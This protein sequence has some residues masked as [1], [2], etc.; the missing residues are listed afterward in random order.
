MYKHI[1]QIS[2][3]ITTI[4]VTGCTLEMPQKYNPCP[5]NSVAEVGKL[6]YILS[7]DNKRCN[8]DEC[9]NEENCCPGFSAEQ[10]QWAR[11]AFQFNVC[12]DA[13]DFNFCAKDNDGLYYCNNTLIVVQECQTN[14]DCS[15]Q[16]GISIGVCMDGECMAQ[17][18]QENYHLNGANCEVDTDANCGAP[19]NACG[20]GKKCVKGKCELTCPPDQTICGERCVNFNQLHIESCSE[21]GKITCLTSFRNC[22]NN[23]EDG[24]EI[25]LQNELHI[26]FCNE[27]TGAIFCEDNYLDCDMKIENGC[28]IQLHDQ[29]TH[30]A[31]CGEELG[32]ITCEPGFVNCDDSLTNGCETPLH[33]E[34]NIDS[35]DENKNILCMEGYANCDGNNA[36]GCEKPTASQHIAQCEDAEIKTC[37]DGWADCDK[38][39]GNGCET[40]IYDDS[41]N[42]G[43][44]NKTCDEYQACNFGTCGI[45]CSDS[46]FACQNQCIQTT[47]HVASCANDIV[48]CESG[49]G[50][51]DGEI[52]NGCVVDLSNNNMNCGKC[53][54]E[55]SNGHLCEN[56]ECSTNCPQDAILCQDFCYPPAM[57]VKSCSDAGNLECAT[58]YKNCSGDLHDG[59]EINIQSDSN[60]CG[61]CNN[62]CAEGKSCI[63]GSCTV[64][65]LSGQKNCGG[66]CV[67]IAS[68]H[69]QDCTEAG[70]LTCV[71][72]FLDCDKNVSNGCEIDMS[73]MHVASCNSGTLQCSL[74]YGDCD[75]LPGNG[76]ETNTMTDINH[77]SKCNNKCDNGKI[78]SSG[79][80]SYNCGSGTTACQGSCLPIDDMHIE[81]CPETGA[82]IC[83]AEYADCDNQIST[84]CEAKIVNDDKNC[85]A[86]G[87]TCDTQNMM[88]CDYDACIINNVC[89]DLAT[90]SVD[91]ENTCVDLNT[92]VNNCGTCG[93]ACATGQACYDGYCMQKCVLDS[94]CSGGKC[95]DGVCLNCT[96]YSPSSNNLMELCYTTADVSSS[97]QSTL[98]FPRAI[99]IGSLTLNNNKTVT[100]INIPNMRSANIITINAN[101]KLKK[102]TFDKLEDVISHFEITENAALNSIDMHSLIKISSKNFSTLAFNDL[103][104]SLSLTS[105]SSIGK[106]EIS[107]NRSLTTIEFPSL[108]TIYQSLRIW[109]N[110]T[111]TSLS[112]PI[113]SY[114]FALTIKYNAMLDSTCAPSDYTHA[115]SGITFTENNNNE[116]SSCD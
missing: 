46:K 49:W 64:S 114:V 31:G 97:T 53:N 88:F 8:W 35:C 52:S 11:E 29:D 111:L 83:K 104:S 15:N 66:E 109:S 14:N 25:P 20:N 70:A 38:E 16:P 92:N 39:Y 84:G 56:S 34:L 30:I 19:G 44:C 77:C 57:H 24:C 71:S 98:T 110:A 61:E 13:S 4:M 103:L 51:C 101:T 107:N 21:D 78:C 87:K 6:S 41:K 48:T 89:G 37:M 112:F 99:Y 67:S 108:T 54:N 55:C 45:A 43:A 94:S 42:C 33:N 23:P 116:L 1:I 58:G 2:I 9:Q 10:K 40:N 27:E 96:T 68:V 85:G 22:N 62:K 69:V 17:Q 59:C 105:L 50:D 7:Q 65:C 18:C 36:N 91:G 75:N 81:S 12:P 72:G 106:F 5:N 74:G 76:C 115:G 100:E 82:L 3:C 63:N 93:L 86:C 26:A 79:G 90:C 113:L 28:E 102:I 73:A 80:C 60:N 95:V 32:S 47:L